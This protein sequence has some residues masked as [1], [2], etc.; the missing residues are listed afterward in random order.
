M[1][2]YFRLM[3]SQVQQ[4]KLLTSTRIVQQKM[5]SL[6]FQANLSFIFLDLYFMKTLHI[7]RTQLAKQF[8]LEVLQPQ[9]N[10]YLN[11][12]QPTSRILA[13]FKRDKAIQEN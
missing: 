1:K 6:K 13:P 4:L 8:S 2:E 9:A 10:V 11:Q 3:L 5:G 12:I 7:S